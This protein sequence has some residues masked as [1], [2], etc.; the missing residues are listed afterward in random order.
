[1]MSQQTAKKS[2]NMI[3]AIGLRPVMAAPMAAPM[4]ACS[5]IGVSRT[6]MG[7]NSSNSP[8]VVLN[9]PPASATSSPKNTTLGSRRISWAMP[10][11]TASR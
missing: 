1:M 9:T 4:I 5:E 2:E 3:S 7:P 8:T 6:R 10:A 11:A